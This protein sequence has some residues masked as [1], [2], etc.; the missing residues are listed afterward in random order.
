MNFRRKIKK[1]HQIKYPSFPPRRNLLN[2]PSIMKYES[3]HELLIKTS[4]HGNGDRISGR[5]IFLLNSKQSPHCMPHLTSP[6]SLSPCVSLSLH[7]CLPSLILSSCLIYL[8][9]QFC[10]LR[11]IMCHFLAGQIM[12]L[13][14]IYHLVLGGASH[15]RFESPLI[16]H[17]Q[18]VHPQLFHE[19]L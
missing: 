16:E 3:C 6:V 7:T 18:V 14:Q 9:T 13:F 12:Y 10:K 11:Y 19:L 5:C 2:L 17:A 1:G 15:W 8:V 4:L